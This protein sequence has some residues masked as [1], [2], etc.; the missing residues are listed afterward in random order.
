MSAMLRLRKFGLT[1]E[2]IV[3]TSE[4]E[5]QD[6]IKPVGFYKRKAG[7]LKRAT[8]MLIEK[9]D[10]DIPDT[11]E[12]LV[13]LPGV[14]PKMGYLALKVAW[15][16]TDGIGVD[17][18]VHRISNRLQWVH[19]DT[20]EQTRE[21]LEAWLPKKYWFDINLLLVGFGQQICASNPK[22]DKCKLTGLCPVYNSSS[23][24]S[25]SKGKQSSSLSSSSSDEAADIE[26]YE[27]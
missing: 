27:A 6:L 22:C 19:S 23:T 4:E 13:K 11:I 12:E 8:E 1:P 25:C 21:Q 26:D 20:P 5:L 14:G 3:Q 15:N 10:G 16:K 18:H 9:Y 24:A 17:V 2:H 7:Y